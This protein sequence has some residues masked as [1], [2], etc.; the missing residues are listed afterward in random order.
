M[1]K[2]VQAE[3]IR[4]LTK[5]SSPDKGPNNRLT[6]NPTHDYKLFNSSY[7]SSQTISPQITIPLKDGGGDWRPL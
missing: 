1:A 2:F 5:M 6:D 3:V 4:S 7:Q